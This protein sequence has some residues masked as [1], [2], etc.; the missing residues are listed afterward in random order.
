MLDEQAKQAR[1]RGQLA[2]VDLWLSV[3]L[4]ATASDSNCGV[5]ATAGVGGLA[6]G[7]ARAELE[8]VAARRI[9]GITGDG[10]QGLIALAACQSYVKEI[11]STK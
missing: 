6:H 10:D 4:N 5:P 9:V 3:L 1:L 2:T 7:A 8:P 11:V